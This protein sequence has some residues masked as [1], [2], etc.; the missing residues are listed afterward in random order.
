MHFRK[1]INLGKSS[2][3]VSLPG[4]WT[5]KNNLKKGDIIRFFESKNNDL[6]LSL[7]DKPLGQKSNN[8]ETL[9]VDNKDINRIRREIISAYIRGFNQLKIIGNVRENRDEIMA[10]LQD[11]IG[12]E[13]AEQGKTLILANDIFDMKKFSINNSLRKMDIA[14]RNIFSEFKLFGNKDAYKNIEIYDSSTNRYMILF[15]RVYRSFLES[16]NSEGLGVNLSEVLNYWELSHH[17]ERISFKLKT[18][19]RSLS[20]V[21]NKKDVNSLLNFLEGV[22]EYYIDVMK[23]YYSKDI[24]MAF[25]LADFKKVLMEKLDNTFKDNKNLQL[26]RCI[27]TTH[28]LILSIH[29]ITRRVYD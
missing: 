25:H 14:V 27:S 21:N 4:S 13:I 28:G 9:N 15:R 19:Y 20:G 11:L 5:K 2:Y 17:F 24:D 26:G 12:T 10:V 18:L 8:V 6:I 3:V 1:V 23:S 16:G 22:S 29:K 7:N